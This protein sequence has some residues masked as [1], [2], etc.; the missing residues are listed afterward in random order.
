M[1]GHLVVPNREKTI[2]PEYGVENKHNVKWS[3][4]S[5]Q[6]WRKTQ[7]DY[8]LVAYDEE[9]KNSLFAVFDGHGGR[10]VA[11]FLKDKFWN[12][13]IKNPNY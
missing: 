2:E 1:G 10:Q 13:L 11:E 7:E 3:A 4:F 12:E 9:K 8:H 5:M 6:G